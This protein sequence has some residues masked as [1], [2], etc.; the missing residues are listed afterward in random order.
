MN[1]NKIIFFKLYYY[2][3]IVW[4]KNSRVEKELNRSIFS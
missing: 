3:K 4:K 2:F 1:E